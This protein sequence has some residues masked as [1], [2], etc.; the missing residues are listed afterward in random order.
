MVGVNDFLIRDSLNK[1]KTKTFV[2]V[3]N[4]AIHSCLRCKSSCLQAKH[5]ISLGLL[6][7][8]LLPPA[9]HAYRH[10]Q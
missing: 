4:N 3:S 5:T 7:E 1:K 8:F 6:Q 9:A 10:N 2:L